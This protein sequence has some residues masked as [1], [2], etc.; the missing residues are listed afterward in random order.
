MP[1]ERY[2]VKVEETPEQ[3]A[4]AVHA[5]GLSPHQRAA[6]ADFAARWR[7]AGEGV[8]VV[9][10]PSDAADAQGARSMTYAVQSSLEGLGVPS[11]QIYL[12]AYVAGDPHGPVLASFQH[13]TATGPDCRG[14]WDNITSDSGN[15]PYA[16]F[17]CALTANF[18]AQLADPR[19]LV[20]PVP[21]AAGDTT[22]REVVLGK[23]RDGQITSAA[24][25]SQASGAASSA[26][27]P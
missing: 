21:L 20:A 16:H 24:K 14:G 13:L 6:L 9:K 8:V 2:A 25:D 27:N 17:G 4:L 12:A 18:A 19:D 5:E 26:V 11:E 15:E 22:R 3:V 23:Y 7:Q 1:T 10:L